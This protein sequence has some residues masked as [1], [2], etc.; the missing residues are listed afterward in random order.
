M[1]IKADQTST[2]QFFNEKP[3]KPGKPEKPSVPSN[4]STPQKPV[5]QTG[6]DPYIFLYGGLLAAALIGGS[7]FAVYYFKKG[8]YS[9]TSPKRTA[10]GISVLS[11]CVLVA[12]AAVFWCSV[13]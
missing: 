7:V 8:K 10:V 11:L 9:R 2:V 1:E 3:E 12:F 6:D 13:T 5:P 4:P